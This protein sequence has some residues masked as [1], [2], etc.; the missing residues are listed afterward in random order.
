MN[1]FDYQDTRKTIEKYFLEFDCQELHDS[2]TGSKKKA[3]DFLV[4]IQM[5][6]EYPKQEWYDTS[7]L[8]TL[9][10]IGKQRAKDVREAIV[11]Q[12]LEALTPDARDVFVVFHDYEVVGQNSLEIDF[13]E[14]EKELSE[15]QAANLIYLGCEESYDSYWEQYERT[16]LGNIAV[17]LET[18]MSG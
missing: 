7:T 17:E 11:A 2:D 8:Y 13:E 6:T 18:R 3:L 4:T 15:L 16:T 10:P 9:T 1:N 12:K 14:C 5:A